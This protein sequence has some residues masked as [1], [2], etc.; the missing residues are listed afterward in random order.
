MKVGGPSGLSVT[1]ISRT[2]I[3]DHLPAD[4][5]ELLQRRLDAIDSNPNIRMI[6]PGVQAPLGDGAVG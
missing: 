1:A 3:P 5:R 6:A 2:E 4:Y